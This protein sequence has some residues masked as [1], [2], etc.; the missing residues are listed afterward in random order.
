MDS[1]S[2]MVAMV[3]MVAETASMLLLMLYGTRE[4][5]LRCESVPSFSMSSERK[6]VSD[7]L[8]SVV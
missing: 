7:C 4:L 2:F 3:A 1:T 8:V 5:R 6:F